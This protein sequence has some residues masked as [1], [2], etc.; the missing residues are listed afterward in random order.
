MQNLNLEPIMQTQTVGQEF[1]RRE[2]FQGS[3]LILRFFK[4]PVRNNFKSAQAGEDVF[5]WV[6]TLEKIVPGSSDT[7]YEKVTD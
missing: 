5:D 3:G 2:P 1:W 4:N 6:D 7:V